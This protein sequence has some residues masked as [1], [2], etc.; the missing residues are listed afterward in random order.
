MKKKN[1]YKTIQP[2]ALP[3]STSF[4]SFHLLI[5]FLLSSHPPFFFHW[6]IFLTHIM[7]IH[8]KNLTVLVLNDNLDS[9]RNNGRII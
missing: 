1:Q 2:Q 9:A 5:Q 3:F 6:Y 4:L 7:Q 8:R